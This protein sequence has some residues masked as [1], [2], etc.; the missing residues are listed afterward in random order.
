MM[1]VAIIPIGKS[2]C[3]FLH[4]SAA[5][6]TESKPMYVKNTIEPPVRIPG[7]PFGA[8]YTD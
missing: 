6:E 8:D 3:G 1:R 2:R 5:V 7:Q 4:S